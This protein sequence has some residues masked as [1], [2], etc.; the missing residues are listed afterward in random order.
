[1]NMLAHARRY[2]PASVRIKSWQIKCYAKLGLVSLVHETSQDMQ[3]L[4]D[5]NTQRLGAYRFTCYSDFGFEQHLADLAKQFKDYF[6]DQINE[7]KNKI[8]SAF[9]AKEFDKVKGLA[10]KNTELERSGFATAVGLTSVLQHM[11]KY[12]TNSIKLHQIFSKHF[13]IVESICNSDTLYESTLPKEAV[14]CTVLKNL[15]DKDL[16]PMM[17][18]QD[19]SEIRAEAL[20]ESAF[21]P[22][23]EQLLLDQTLE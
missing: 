22:D 1:M 9:C 18:N 2:F 11:G 17:L 6:K 7:N 12:S 16:K 4:S 23:G 10:R 21:T 13:G 20:L 5:L 19:R 14:E 3:D 15:R 8:V